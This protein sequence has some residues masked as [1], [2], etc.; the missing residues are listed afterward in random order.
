MAKRSRVALVIETSTSYG[1][2]ILRGIRRYA[3]THQSWSIFLEQRDLSG[4]PPP[5]IKNWDGDGIISRITT[6]GMVEDARRLK[7]PLIDLTDR[8]ETLSL[9][10]VWSN[11]GAIARLGA[12]HL[13]ERGFRNFG[14]CGFS[15]EIWAGRR[16]DA[17]VEAAGRAGSECRIYESPWFG[18][19]AHP[20]ELEQ[21]QIMAWLSALPKPAGVMACNDYRGQHVLDA[22]GRL[23]LAVPEE[24][25]VIGVDDEEELCELCEPP[26]SSVVPNAEMVGYKAAEL[27]DLLMAGGQAVEPRLE[28]PPIAVVTRQ[29]TDVLAIDDP[30]IA[31]AVRYIRENAC[32]GAKVED[33]LDDVPI[34]RSI[35]ERRF[36]KYLGL[37]PQS[38]IRQTRLKRVKQ[39]LVDTDLT[40]ARIS[41]L[42]GFRHQEHM[43]VLFKKE[44]GDSPG[45]Y[46]RKVQGASPFIDS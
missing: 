7:I 34:S 29:S 12:E 16:R 31:A 39:L 37:S 15:H 45:A 17:F 14:F 38:L 28:I 9:H 11:D 13:I 24:I 23:D 36:R 19:D 5:W 22:C 21:K 41:T 46:R 2:R 30:E 27:L 3:H 4:E 43:C 25:A 33:I 8:H 40:L 44:I 35:L 10:Q 6:R 26:L 32:R 18:R 42:A 1:R 20:W